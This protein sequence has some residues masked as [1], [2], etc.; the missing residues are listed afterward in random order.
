MSRLERVEAEL[1]YCATLWGLPNSDIVVAV[2]NETTGGPWSAV[3]YRGDT[4]IGA[5][6]G[7]RPPRMRVASNQSASDDALVADAALGF[8]LNGPSKHDEED[9]HPDAYMEWEA[10]Q[11]LLESRG[12]DDVQWS[13]L[14]YVEE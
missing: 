14:V 7:L 11:D 2:N 1:G 6:H 8:G 3:F 5:L 9:L 4:R 13:E 10:I 12:Y